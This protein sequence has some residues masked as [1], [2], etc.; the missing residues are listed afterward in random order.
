MRIFKKPSIPTTPLAPTHHKGILWPY[1]GKNLSLGSLPTSVRTEPNW[2]DVCNFRDLRAAHGSPS[3]PQT[4]HHIQVSKWEPVRGHSE[5]DIQTH[6]LQMPWGDR[7]LLMAL[8]FTSE[9]GC[10]G[11]QEHPF[12]VC[13]PQKPPG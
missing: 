7:G 1:G 4:C 5:E 8:L 6:N 12:V 9:G 13:S 11:Q 10:A 3:D 2:T